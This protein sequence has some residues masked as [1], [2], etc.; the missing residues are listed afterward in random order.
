[1]EC[2]IFQP[3]IQT[4]TRCSIRSGE[5][6]RQQFSVVDRVGIT[7]ANWIEDERE[8]FAVGPVQLNTRACVAKQVSFN[9]QPHIEL[10]V[11]ASSDWVAD[12][13]F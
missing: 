2:E 1:M 9:T 6:H 3:R 10:N 13:G 4:A 7:C 5:R 12:A 8:A 11:T